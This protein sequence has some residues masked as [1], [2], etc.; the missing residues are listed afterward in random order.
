MELESILKKVYKSDGDKK[1][2]YE[3]KKSLKPV[4]IYG[5][6]NYSE[7][8]YDNLKNNDI[9]TEA[10]VVDRSYWKSGLE[11]RNRP[12]RCIDDYNIEKYNIVVGFG[13]VD[14]SRFLINNK[15][16]LNS[17][18]YFLWDPVMYYEWDLEYIK[19]NWNAYVD[20]YNG[21]ED[22]KS[23]NTL[24]ELLIAKLN[25]CCTP[26]L[27][28]IAD[29]KLHYFNE[30][31][32]CNNTEK[33]IFIDCGAY[34]GDTILQYNQF[35][36]GNYKKI[37]AFEPNKE[38]LVDL[39]KNI[40]SLHD[41]EVINKGTWNKNTILKFKN[42][43]E[44]SH[45]TTIDEGNIVEVTTIDSV[46][47]TEDKITFIKMDIEGSELESLQ[48]AINFIKRDMPKMAICCY[49]KKNDII[50]LFHFMKKIENSNVRYKI[51]LRHHSNSSCETI[52]YGIPC[53]K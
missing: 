45:I 41:I 34:I 19:D 16:S 22:E 44:V 28:N 18:F 20:V 38:F 48:G 6:S 3:L 4:L 33:E 36:K 52:L 29:E 27:L 7:I 31:T 35:T 39:D 10:F 51:F 2:Y 32:F 46:V 43:K 42:N 30:L 25:K 26:Q 13:D 47:K 40:K 8:I 49:H 50:D 37:Y 5:A 11:I 12:V 9:N 24:Y 17:S 53:L 23:K 1:V 14:K 15:K 21:L